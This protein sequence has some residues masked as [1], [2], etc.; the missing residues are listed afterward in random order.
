LVQ[1]KTKTKFRLALALIGL[2]ETVKAK[3]LFLE[4]YTLDPEFALDTK[5]F[6]PKVVAVAAEAK[7]DAA[8]SFYRSGV[9]AYRRGEIQKALSDLKGAIALSP[10][11]DL[12]LQYVDLIQNKQQLSQDRQRTAAD[13][14]RVNNEYRK[15]L[16]TLVEMWNRTCAAG[17]TA[18]MNSIRQQISALSPDPSFGADIRAGMMTTCAEPPKAAVVEPAPV[19]PPPPPAA[20]VGCLEMQTQLAL[21]RL[22]TR[23]D[24]II[25]SEIRTFFKNTQ[26]IKVRLKVRISDAGDVA[27]LGVTE[28]TPMVNSVVTAAVSQWKF[29]PSRDQSGLRCV[30]TEIPMLLKLSQ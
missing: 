14:D 2:N 30:D 23:V 20:P 10:E 11:H 1:D 13:I 26:E 18:A 17:D 16:T 27:I 24:P 4:L 19:A 7:S 28:G 29:T 8:E 12:A 21:T 15:A 3:A 6:A 9:A 25:T 22:K 5:Q